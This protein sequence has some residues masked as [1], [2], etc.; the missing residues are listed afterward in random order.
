MI[1]EQGCQQ[2]VRRFLE[3]F[4]PQEPLILGDPLNLRYFANCYVDPF[5]LGGDFGALLKI[6][7]DGKTK[8]FLDARLPKSVEAAFAHEK[9]KIVWYTGKAP[10][11]GP[12]RMSI[13]A[14]LNEVG[15]RRVH[16]QIND[17]DAERFWDVVTDLRRSKDADEVEQLRACMKAGEAGH[18]WARANVRAGMTELEVYNGIFSACALAVGQ[19]VILYGDFTVSPGSSKRG[20]PPTT[21]TLADGET[22]ILDFSVVIGGY[23]SDYTN[24]ICVGGK[25]TSEQR[26]IFDLS[27]QAMAAGEQF[28]KAGQSC[29]DVYQA[30]R[31][32]F[33][34]EKLADNFPHHAGHGLGISHPE[35]PFFVAHATETLREG[36]VVTLE[37]GLYVDN[38]GG[39]RIENNYLVT[40]T[41]FEQLSHHQISLD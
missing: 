38:V 40:A 24:T 19:P 3:A 13:A 34:A 27:K 22:L 7:P 41:G 25:P 20:G 16:D 2:R 6:D 29:L 23:R 15:S 10:G 14:A 5:S 11:Q 12:R 8:L 28:L 36:D 17:P 21:H 1:T 26:R 32:V 18:A 30:V 9:E 31:A 35:A 37:P 33:E 39:V 4:R